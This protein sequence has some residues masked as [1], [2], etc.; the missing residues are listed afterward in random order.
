MT[1]ATK[2]PAPDRAGNT[3]LIWVLMALVCSGT[4]EGG[5]GMRLRMEGMVVDVGVGVAGVVTPAPW[6]YRSEGV[7]GGGHG[8]VSRWV[9]ES[10]VK[11]EWPPGRWGGRWGRVVGPRSWR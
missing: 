6:A 4:V 5:T 9:E 8:Q 2:N 11:A 1:K 7:R 3:G 10:G